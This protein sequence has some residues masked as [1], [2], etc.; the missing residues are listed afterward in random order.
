[1]KA[2]WLNLRDLVYQKDVRKLIYNKLSRVD[3]FLASLA[4]FESRSPVFPLW[5]AE[6]CIKT[7]DLFALEF[8]V[9][10]GYKCPPS[11]LICSIEHCRQE[12]FWFL[13]RL[14][15]F[16]QGSHDSLRLAAKVG[17]LEVLVHGIEEANWYNPEEDRAYSDQFLPH[18]AAQFGQIHVL[19]W[20]KNCTVIDGILSKSA[21]ILLKVPLWV[22]SLQHSNG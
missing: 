18:I 16:Q 3:K 17:N 11:S 22:G 13:N 7:D 1:M 20:M 15:G 10:H 5:F 8:A 19:E 4:H 9:K 2:S 14:G 6:E 12:I 21:L